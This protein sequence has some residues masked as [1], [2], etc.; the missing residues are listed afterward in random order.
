MNWLLDPFQLEFQQRALAAGCLA[1]V[2]TAV[3]GTWVIIRGMSFLSDAL[4]HG[5]L[6]GIALA[7]VWGLDTTAGAALS[8]AVMVVGVNAVN[9]RTRV[10]SDTSIGLLFVGMLAVGVVII[11][12]SASYFG[13]LT[14]F[15]FGDLLGVSTGDI[16]IEAGAA[17]VIVVACVVLYRPFL[18]L[19]LN[20][21]KAALF[22]MRPGATNLAMLGLIALAVV[23]SF[24]AVGTL[25][26]SGL[27]IAPPAAASLVT[28]R[29]PVLMA[30]AALLGVAS[31]TIGLV[32][33][34]HYD[35]AAGATAAAVAV[36]LFFI[37]AL[38]RGAR[39]LVAN[40][41]AMQP[42]ATG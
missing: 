34:Y 11:S 40:R 19:C 26:V 3:I 14:A 7:F 16:W 37:A 30:V 17:V 22:G 2:A 38:V 1:A 13:D 35:T 33:S 42:S 32:L 18:V 4:A 10:G 8:A 31:V 25:L 28:R 15:L 23:A 41:Q 39:Q 36:G 12:R 20:E 24:Q 29:V 6:P 21:D 27:L 9:R 5:V